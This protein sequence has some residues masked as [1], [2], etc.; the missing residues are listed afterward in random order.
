MGKRLFLAVRPP[1]SVIDELEAY[2]GPRRDAEPELRWVQPEHW[3]VT[4]C[5]LGNRVTYDLEIRLLEYLGPVA[6][7]R[8][9]FRLTLGGS[10]YLQ[11]PGM[12]KHLRLGV[13]EGASE[14]EALA[15]RCRTA[16]ARSDIH[17]DPGRYYPHLT[18]ARAGRGIAARRWLPVIDSF[19]SFSW[20]VDEFLLIDSELTAGGPRHRVAERFELAGDERMPR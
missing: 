19:G 4:L 10:G 2:V 14:L 17:V 16:A 15:M 12:L 11:H 9:P 5:F 3:H 20:E 6:D 18:L 8:A 1:A 7:R 13:Q